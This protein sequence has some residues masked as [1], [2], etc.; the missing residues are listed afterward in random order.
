M[1][2][3]PIKP[4][5]TLPGTKR[6]K[7]EC[8]ELLSKFAFKSNLRRYTKVREFFHYKRASSLFDAESQLLDNLSDNIRQAGRLSLT[9]TTPPTLNRRTDSVLLYEHSPCS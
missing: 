9:A 5:L 8:D 7:L 6:Q 1:Q 4:K 2:V 3:D